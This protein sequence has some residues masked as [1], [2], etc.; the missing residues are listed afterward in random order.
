MNSEKFK[1]GRS[2]IEKKNNPF[3]IAGKLVESL[4]K[5]AGMTRAQAQAALTNN[6]E[7]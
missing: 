2:A 3:D 5:V 1:T 7:I 4:S 6:K